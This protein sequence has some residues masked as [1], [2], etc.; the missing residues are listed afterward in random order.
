MSIKCADRQL[1]AKVGSQKWYVINIFFYAMNFAYFNI[2][3]VF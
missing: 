3:E 2:L 1:L